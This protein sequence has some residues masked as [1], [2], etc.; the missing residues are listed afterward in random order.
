VT[1]DFLHSAVTTYRLGKI[2]CLVDLE[3]EIHSRSQI[4]PRQTKFREFTVKERCIGIYDPEI[5]ARLIVVHH[6]ENEIL[7]YS[8]KQVIGFIGRFYFQ[9]Y[10]EV[11]LAQNEYHL[12]VC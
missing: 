6:Y 4:M 10:W 3:K 11:I 5:N 2:C 7:I 12:H 9:V 8:R 1:V